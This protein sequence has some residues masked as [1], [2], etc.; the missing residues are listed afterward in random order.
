[1]MNKMALKINRWERMNLVLR[2]TMRD[3]AGLW[4]MRRE[5]G[6]LYQVQTP[7]EYKRARGRVFIAFLQDQMSPGITGL[8]R[9][10]MAR[11]KAQR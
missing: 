4:W 7:E 9:K 1:M 5:L 6:A 10:I 2:I 11:W 8:P 3:E